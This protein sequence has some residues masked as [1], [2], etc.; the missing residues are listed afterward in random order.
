ADAIVMRRAALTHPTDSTLHAAAALS[1]FT[2]GG[3]IDDANGKG[4]A[5]ADRGWI[6]GLFDLIDYGHVDAAAYAA[7][8]L[9]S[10]YADAPFIELMALVG[11][12]LP[13]AVTAGRQPFSDAPDRDVQVVATPGATCAIVAFCGA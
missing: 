9:A 8:L 1:A 10:R 3:P 13:A 11:E 2:V 5:S 6:T 4:A 7:K 12:S